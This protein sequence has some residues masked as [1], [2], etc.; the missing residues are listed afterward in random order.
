VE[1][2]DTYSYLLGDWLVERAIEDCILRSLGA[3]VPLR[4]S[5]CSAEG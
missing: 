3:V 4:V 5:Q 1:V 2:P